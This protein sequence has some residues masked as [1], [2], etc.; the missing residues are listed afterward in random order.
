MSENMGFVKGQGTKRKIVDASMELFAQ[1]GYKGTSVR[2]IASSVGIKQSA[3]YNH[4]ANKEAIFMQIATEIFSTP[5][6]TKSDSALVEEQAKRGK[7]FL[8][9]FANEI[10][11]LAFDKRSE[12]LFRFMM[13]E[14][15]QHAQLREQFR[16]RF[17]D[18]NIEYLSTGL[19]AMMRANLIRS[20]DPMVMAEAFLAP[21]FYL[22]FNISL[23]KADEKP[24]ANYSKQFE[25]HLDF[26]WDSIKRN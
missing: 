15:M 21:L 3:L 22:R 17:H 19:F 25:K 23:Q 9:K 10:R 20:C 24:T 13:I 26:F 16:A 1:H 5:F 4:F 12:K 7:A 2:A 6:A 14:I 18:D 8:S 11:L